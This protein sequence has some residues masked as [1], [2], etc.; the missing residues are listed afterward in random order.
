MRN[1][2]RNASGSN[3]IANRVE[4][5]A[6]QA[7]ATLDPS[8]L[9]TR[10]VESMSDLVAEMVLG[11]RDDDDESSAAALADAAALEAARSVS[12]APIA[13]APPITPAF[14]HDVAMDVDVEWDARAHDGS[15]RR[16]RVALVVTL[17]ALLLAGSGIAVLVTR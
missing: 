11:A 3:P 15:R 8:D 1:R 16:G 6:M 10:K 9:S 2:A 4:C 17:G 5:A 7:E 13:P 14:H 12:F